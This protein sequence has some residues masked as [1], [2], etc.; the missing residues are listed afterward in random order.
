M[1]PG[2]ARTEMGWDWAPELQ[3]ELLEEW[4]RWGI[5]RHMHF[6]LP[7]EVAE[8]VFTTVTAPPGVHLDVVQ[9]NPSK[10]PDA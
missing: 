3:K 2:P 7:E 9:I 8:A 1:R 5:L 10:P 4:G 6:M